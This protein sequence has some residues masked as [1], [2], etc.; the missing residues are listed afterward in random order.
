MSV[1]NQKNLITVGGIVVALLVGT[2]LLGGFAKN[3]PAV[4]ETAMTMGACPATG[5][6]GCP[7]AKADSA[8]H[9]KTTDTEKSDGCPCGGVC[10]PDCPKPCCAKKCCEESKPSACCGSEGETET[11]MQ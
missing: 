8:A 1:K 2:V 6:G 3:E 5:C 7:M 10:P 4:T 11:A 9:A